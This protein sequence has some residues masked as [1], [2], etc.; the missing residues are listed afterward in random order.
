MNP[1]RLKFFVAGAVILVAML[2]LF[3]ASL[4]QKGASYYIPVS[5]FVGTGA[6]SV[7]DFRINGKVRS[8][9]VVQPAGGTELNFV[10]V[11][12]AT[13]GA[14]VG[15]G[16]LRVSYRGVVPDTFTDTADV[17]VEGVMGA[18]GVFQATTLLAKCPSKYDTAGGAPAATS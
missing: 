5:E 13:S 10:M 8:G 9:T 12:S 4:N 2:A 6:S 11:D 3:G 1:T 16:E 14:P 17:V 7:G 15:P 18:D